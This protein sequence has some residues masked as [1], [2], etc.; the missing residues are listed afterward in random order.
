MVKKVTITSDN[1]ELMQELSKLNDLAERLPSLFESLARIGELGPELVRVELS[2]DATL[3]AGEL[4][5]LLK[6]TELLL[7]L[8]AALSAGDHQF[9]I[10]NELA[11]SCLLR[12]SKLTHVSK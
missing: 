10:A 7:R 1:K 5:V 8:V 2:D 12:D 3:G 9:R 6:P 4:R 11:H